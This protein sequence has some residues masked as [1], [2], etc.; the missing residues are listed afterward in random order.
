[1]NIALI[2]DDPAQLRLIGS[3]LKTAT[4]A[5]GIAVRT[6]DTYPSPSALLET[7]RAGSY[8]ILLLDIYMGEE[9]GVTLAR[10]LR[11]H[12]PEAVL[13]F[14][15][16]SNEFAAESYEVGAGY[17][18]QKP[19]SL[20]KLTAMLK[21]L[22]LSKIER[23]R[24]VRLPDGSQLLLRH[25]LYTEYRNHS[26]LFHLKDAPARSVYMNH[27]DA[28]ALLLHYKSFL[29]INKGCIVNLAGVKK[30]AATAFTMQNGE[31]LP[32]S[33]RRCKEVAEAYTLYHFEQLNR[34]VDT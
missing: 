20:E 26:V 33:R 2:D 1:M 22:N 29:E 11:E 18:L 8:H 6:I 28:E 30:H 13:V 17:Y 34:E 9:N 15:T 7:W 3:M 10:T 31:V 16:S 24:T 5:L 23:N 4:N 12:D 32:I 19:V 25:I 21:R 14:C 27:R